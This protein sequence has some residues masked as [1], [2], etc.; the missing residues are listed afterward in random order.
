MPE[1]LTIDELAGRVGMTAR[2]IRAHQ[3]RGLLPPPDLEGRTGF[4]GSEHVARLKLI[5]DMQGAGFNLAAI[6]KLVQ[7]AP[8][9]SA[10]EVLEFERTLLRPWGS[11]N[12]RVFEAAELAN[13]FGPVDARVLQRAVELGVLV[14]NGDGRF[15]APSPSLLRAGADLVALG[16]PLGSVVEVLDVL[17]TQSHKI[18]TSFVNL[19]IEN[20]WKP[21]ESRGRPEEDW[22]RIREAVE[23]LRPLATDAL[24]VVFRRQMTTAVEEAFGRELEQQDAG[25]SEAS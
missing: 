17:V 22:P 2:N 5:K 16:V 15:V 12:P 23:E 19:F 3:S 21:F 20:V 11:E 14:D 4:Y 25:E 1:R 9:G 10:Q 18:S 6:K 8:V 24:L 13:L 7:A